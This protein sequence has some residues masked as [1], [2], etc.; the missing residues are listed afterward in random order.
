MIF[1]ELNVELKLLGVMIRVLKFIAFT[2]VTALVGGINLLM[3]IIHMGQ[4]TMFG[5][6]VSYAAV[7][8]VVTFLFYL[9]GFAGYASVKLSFT[10]AFTLPAWSIFGRKLNGALVCWFV[11]WL[12]VVLLFNIFA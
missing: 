9:I 12:V 3:Y 5:I 4:G 8:P 7:A 2:I 6:P 1:H 11:S 10:D